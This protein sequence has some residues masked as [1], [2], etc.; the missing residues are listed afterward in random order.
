M[1]K[2]SEI[3]QLVLVVAFFFLI[4]C[5]EEED[6]VVM[7]EE[8]VVRTGELLFYSKFKNISIKID[9]EPYGV[10]EGITDGKIP[11]CG[12]SDLRGGMLIEL[13]HGYHKLEARSQ[14]GRWE[15]DVF[16][17]QN[18]CNLFLLR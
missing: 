6:E 7:P 5:K 3:S 9:G 2:F 15:G 10:M 1:M 17:Y 13:P 18:E 14:Q 11:R 8:N 4:S 12:Y 16:F